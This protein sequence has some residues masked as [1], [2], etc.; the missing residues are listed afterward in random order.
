MISVR[1]VLV[2]VDE[3]GAA[4]HAAERAAALAEA[5]GAALHLVH[6]VPQGPLADLRRL[7]G[8]DP[9]PVER[10]LA[11][12]RASIE[13]LATELSRPTRRPFAVH[14]EQGAVLGAIDAV[15]ERIDADLVVFGSRGHGFLSRLAL[16]S[17]AERMLRR[18][19]RPMLV[20]RQ[21]PRAPYQRVL[22]AVD[23]SPWS[24]PAL[25]L[26]RRLA[27]AARLTVLHVLN[28]P[29][30]AK[31]RQAGIDEATIARYRE[32][33]RREAELELAELTRRC[34]LA[35]HAHDALI[36]HGDPARVILEQEQEQDA[37]LVI[38]GKHGRSATESFLLGSVTKQVLAHGSA[39]V[40]VCP[41]RAARSETARRPKRP[42]D[43]RAALDR[44]AGPRCAQAVQRATDSIYGTE[45]PRQ[46]G[47]LFRS[48]GWR[49]REED[50]DVFP[51][52]RRARGA[53]MFDSK[54][55]YPA[56]WAA[57]E[58]IAG[59]IGCTPETLRRWVRQAER[60]QGKRPDPTTS[61]TERIKSL[62][63]EV[64]ELR[65]AN[66]IPRKASAF[67]GQTGL[68]RLES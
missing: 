20:V 58:S 10:V 66:E 26:A 39:D 21:K 14:V 7:L 13:R 41:K 38:L 31:L 37:D 52:G 59:E 56:Q 35:A 67:F 9:A 11:A 15:A 22:A 63:R 34:G 12:Q 6:V 68:G 27:P 28:P 18:G 3:S 1:T 44:P 4:R 61:E 54:G 55:Q 51:G 49:H 5:L 42:L 65:Q 57:V 50:P 33:A 29:F 60:D 32:S 25:E 16:G 24:A 48:R 17:T 8:D 2:A 43:E 45:P 62:A 30:E 40:L 53:T 23:F 36:E 46:S 19:S 64:R 47:R